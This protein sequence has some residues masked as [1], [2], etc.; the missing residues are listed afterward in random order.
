MS[1]AGIIV[2]NDKNQLVLNCTYVNLVLTRVLR[3]GDLPV[4]KR[5]DNLYSF[6]DH[7]GTRIQ[8]RIQLADNE[9]LVA[10]EINTRFKHEFKF[11]DYYTE[12]NDDGT[13]K[14][15]ESF[16]NDGS[17]YIQIPAYTMANEKGY[18]RFAEEVR[19]RR[20]GDSR[21]QTGNAFYA[22]AYEQN[23]INKTIPIVNDL[24]LYV[25]G[26]AKS[27]DRG[28]QG[29]ILYDENGK[30]VFNSN[31]KYMRVISNLVDTL[32]Y[33]FPIKN[34]T[35]ASVDSSVNLPD[36]DHAGW[37]ADA[38]LEDAQFQTYIDSAVY[39]EKDMIS[40]AYPPDKEGYVNVTRVNSF[41]PGLAVSMW[42]ASQI[43][44]GCFLLDVTGY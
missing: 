15:I 7:I 12:C 13:V 39:G 44:K 28:S 23:E 37:N 29:M 16:I 19:Y 8:K 35:Y 31:N 18:V 11:I 20:Y 1:D 33:S 34:H 32:N 14:S 36:W 4:Y 3:W 42:G 6:R 43:S 26:L 24:R 27:D 22:N 30:V 41:H 38:P 25:F 21:E 2:N 5:D 17:E 10:R 40:T 9:L